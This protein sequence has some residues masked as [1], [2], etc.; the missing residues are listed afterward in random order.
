MAFIQKHVGKLARYL[1]TFISGWLTSVGVQ[2]DSAQME[3]LIAAIL[4]GLVSYGYSAI[5]KP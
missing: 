4:L 5:K 1:A 2:S 3:S